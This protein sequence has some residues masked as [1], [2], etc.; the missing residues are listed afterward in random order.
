M[1]RS[2]I[3]I[4]LGPPGSG[5]G[6]VS[7]SIEEQLRIPQLSTGDMLRAAVAAGTATGQQA[8]D[9]MRRGAL[10]P[11]ELVT[12]IIR[13]RIQEEDCR[14]GFLLDGFPRTVAQ[15][16]ALDDL[17]AREGDCVTQVI[18]LN[19][20]DEVLTERICG[21]WIHKASGR[22]YHVKNK[23]PR[24]YDGRSEPTVENM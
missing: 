13:E 24:S 23:M 11:D 18:E 16:Q 5:K 6:T 1:P 9:L 12:Q 17:L 2:N 22:S 14:G 8:Q 7:P 19:V 21:R 10:V 20:P 3:I 15:A 4:L